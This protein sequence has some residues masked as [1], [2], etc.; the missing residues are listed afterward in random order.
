MA[1]KGD[2]FKVSDTYEIIY[3]SIEERIGTDK[4]EKISSYLDMV[5]DR[6]EHINLTAVR[7][8]DEALVKQGDY[9]I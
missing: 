1:R 8:R 9:S 5:L 3:K 7:D 2:A 4:A 6:N